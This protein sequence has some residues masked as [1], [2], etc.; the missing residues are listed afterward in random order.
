M[1]AKTV[2]NYLDRDSMVHKMTGTTK[3]AFFPVVH[4]R[5]YDHI[6]H[7]GAAWAVRSKFC[8]IQAQ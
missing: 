8:G 5:K 4:V 2:L 1:A 3:L 6:Q 7:M